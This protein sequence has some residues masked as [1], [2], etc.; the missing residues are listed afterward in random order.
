MRETALNGRRHVRAAGLM[1][2]RVVDRL[3]RCS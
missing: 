1:N 3:G 2:V